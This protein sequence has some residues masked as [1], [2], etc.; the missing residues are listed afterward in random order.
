MSYFDFVKFFH[1]VDI[2]K[3][4]SEWME[5]RMTGYFVSHECR[6]ILAYQ[7]HIF[8]TTQIEMSLFQRSDKGR[9]EL[10]DSDLLL[11]VFR[12]RRPQLQFVTSSKRLVRHFINKEHMFGAGEYTILPLSFNFWYTSN[13]ISYNLAV[14]GSK[15]FILEQSIVPNYYLAD[16]LI[17]LAVNMG[18]R[19]DVT[20]SSTNIYTLSDEFSGL[21]VVAENLDPVHSFHVEITG[22]GSVNVVSTRQSL[23]TCDSVPPLYRQVLIILTQLES[24]ESYS[25]NYGF[26]IKL[27]SQQCF[28]YRNEMNIMNFPRLNRNVSSLHSPRPI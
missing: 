18:K 17:A 4:H 13:K 10:I 1:S 14:H 7:L 9:R 21:V 23:T 19:S 24:S 26:K 5:A 2:C 20:F 27:K 22:D 15:P 6:D 25:I 12:T 8:E 28:N 11:L 3:I 16:A